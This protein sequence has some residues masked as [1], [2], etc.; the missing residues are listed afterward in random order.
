MQDVQN[1]LRESAQRVGDEFMNCKLAARAKVLPILMLAL[2]QRSS[3]VTVGFS[4]SAR[5]V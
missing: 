1:K 3:R 2:P 4:L 5:P